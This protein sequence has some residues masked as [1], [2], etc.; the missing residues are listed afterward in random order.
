MTQMYG[1]HERGLKNSAENWFVVSEAIPEVNIWRKE[2]QKE[3]NESKTNVFETKKWHTQS[4]P[5][6]FKADGANFLSLGLL[7]GKG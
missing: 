2:K 3:R 7:Q 6:D 1:I 5:F 4:I